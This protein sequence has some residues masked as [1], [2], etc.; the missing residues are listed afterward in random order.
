M[1]NYFETYIRPLIIDEIINNISNNIINNSECDL[2]LLR[3]VFRSTDHMI[4]LPIT[5]F[6][7]FLIL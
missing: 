3:Y 4:N 7:Y 6:D 2:L 1:Q 5:I